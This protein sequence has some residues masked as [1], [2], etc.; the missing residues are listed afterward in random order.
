MKDLVLHRDVALQLHRFTEKPSH[1]LMLIGPEGAGKRTLALHLSSALL[2]LRATEALSKHP[3]YFLLE[4]DEGVQRIEAI[5]TLQNKVRLKTPGSAA[6]R[7]VIVIEAAHTMTL[8]AQN[9]L[10][11]LLEEPPSDTV[12]VLNVVGQRSL[13]PTVYS[14]AQ[15]IY[16]RPPDKHQLVQAF[17]NR[18][19]NPQ[20]VESAYHLSGGQ[21]G[22]LSALLEQDANHSL[23]SAIVE[24]KR[25]LGM[26]QYERLAHL[27]ILASQKQAM[28]EFLQALQRIARAALVQAG[29]RNS[30]KDIKRWHHCV[31]SINQAQQATVHNANTKLLLTNLLLG[32]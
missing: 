24:A 12:L 7:R 14:R 27:G 6:I 9:A 18:G 1:A 20:T 15:H 2:A 10:L 29:T 26:S 21:V 13:L 32:L 25:I 8:Q 19:H 28:P 22:L 16:V 17:T 5:R 23:S 3:Y 30:I 31:Q 11:K 4:P